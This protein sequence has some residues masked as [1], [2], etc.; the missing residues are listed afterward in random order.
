MMNDL[1]EALLRPV[2]E[3]IGRACTDAITRWI[4]S[5]QA[6]AAPVENGRSIASYCRRMTV[7]M[8]VCVGI[9]S[10][11]AIL[12]LIPPSPVKW[13]AVPFTLFAIASVAGLLDCMYCRFE[14]N[15]DELIVQSFWKGRR[16]IPWSAV[17]S[18]EHSMWGYRTIDA[19]MYGKVKISQYLSGARTLVD[20][21]EAM[22]KERGMPTRIARQRIKAFFPGQP[23][24]ALK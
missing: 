11:I 5:G 14:F 23:L 2:V 24:R 4:L 1:T 6:D 8:G 12:C 3:S 22:V 15:R 10:A 7:A 21:V 13:I 16:T 9:S 20:L 19:G 17:R 18:L